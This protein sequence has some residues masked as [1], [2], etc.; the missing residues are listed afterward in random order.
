MNRDAIYATYTDKT[1]KRV[2]KRKVS[3]N[4]VEVIE[5]GTGNVI[6]TYT[7]KRAQR[8]IATYQ[9][10]GQI[11]KPAVWED[12]Y[13]HLVDQAIDSMYDNPGWSGMLKADSDFNRDRKSGRKQSPKPLSQLPPPPPKGKY[14]RPGEDWK[15]GWN[16][17]TPTEDGNYHYIISW[18]SDGRGISSCDKIITH[19][20]ALKP[21]DR[22]HCPQCKRIK[23]G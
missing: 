2:G 4:V 13:K 14:G 9:S 15:L 3:E 21:K 10:S 7:D 16:G 20:P 19:D 5:M 17:C 18:Y 1:G 23:G 6:R 11:N 8:P 12:Q 22:K